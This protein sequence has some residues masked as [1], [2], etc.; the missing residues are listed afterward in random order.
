MHLC[1]RLDKHFLQ[2]TVKKILYFHLNTCIAIGEYPTEPTTFPI[3]RCHITLVDVTFPVV[4]SNTKISE[5]IHCFTS[6][7]IWKG[8]AEAQAYIL[9]CRNGSILI[10]QFRSSRRWNLSAN[11]GAWTLFSSTIWTYCNF[12]MR[13]LSVYL[14]WTYIICI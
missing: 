3:S 9:S 14:W 8:L 2:S 13:Y 12:K 10:P 1:I 5:N 7:C 6:G 4:I 11:I